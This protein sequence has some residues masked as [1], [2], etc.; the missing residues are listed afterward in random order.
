MQLSVNCPASLLALFEEYANTPEVMPVSASAQLTMSAQRIKEATES[1]DLVFDLRDLSVSIE[2]LLL[3]SDAQLDFAVS[4]QAKC[5]S[6]AQVLL[7]SYFLTNRRVRGAGMYETL[8]IAR[9][10]ERMT[11]N[12]STSLCTSWIPCRSLP[13]SVQ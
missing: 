3:E 10:I 13:L 1:F 7:K 12:D 2:Q 6:E 5:S 4:H 11:A 9:S 8:N